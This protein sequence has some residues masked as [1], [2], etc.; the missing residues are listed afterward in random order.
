MLKFWPRLLIASSLVLTGCVSTISAVSERPIEPDRSRP[1]MGT[2]IDDLQLET[3]IAVNIKKAH[4]LLDRSSHVNINAYN[5]VVLLTGEVP[6]D[7]MRT[8]AG[9]T[10]RNTRGVRQVHNE[11]QIK[12]SSSL[13]ARSRD[14]WL[15]TKVK[16]KLIND[17]GIKSNN[18]EVI[19][20]D[21]VIY[22]MGIITHA[23]ADK[24]ASIAAN[25]SGARSVVKVFEYIQ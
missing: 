14:S 7:E 24:A 15:T 19:T 12:G 16:T 10:A 9:T 2:H 4:S 13:L 23:E 17:P 5:R 11:L 25:T 18:I 22:L 21:K 3:V 1:S 8:L 6:T 20:E